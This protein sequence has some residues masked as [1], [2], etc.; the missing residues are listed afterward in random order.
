MVVKGA[1]PARSRLFR[2]TSSPPTGFSHREMAFNN[3]HGVRDL[4][5][6]SD[7]PGRSIADGVDFVAYGRIRIDIYTCEF[8]CRDDGAVVVM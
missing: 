2:R 5:M 3:D 6:N 7:R 1:R 4:E 8:R